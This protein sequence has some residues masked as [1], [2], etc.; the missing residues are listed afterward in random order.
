MLGVTVLGGYATVIA[1]KK[2]IGRKVDLTDPK[3]LGSAIAYSGFFGVGFDEI[4]SSLVW[5]NLGGLEEL[6]TTVVKA[7]AK[8]KSSFRTLHHTALLFNPYRN[9]SVLGDLINKYTV[10][11]VFRLLDPAGAAAYEESILRQLDND[12]IEEWRAR[13]LRGS[14]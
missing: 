14:N 2:I 8:P 6:P 12:Q 1:K 7:L 4:L 10:D 11:Q 9:I 13:V 5:S 3:T